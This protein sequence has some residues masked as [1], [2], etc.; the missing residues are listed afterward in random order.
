MP[1]VGESVADRTVRDKLPLPRVGMGGGG[2]SDDRDIPVRPATGGECHSDI[3]TARGD[4][5]DAAY[6][7]V[8]GQEVAEVGSAVSKYSM[9]D[10]VGVGCMVDS[11]R[12]CVNCK[13]GEEQYCFQ[14]NVGTYGGFLDGKPTDTWPRPSCAP[15]SRCTRRSGAGVRARARR[16]PSSGWAGSGTWA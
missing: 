1:P 3:H 9:G 4:W 13:A 16:S 10:R 15:A 7:L 11:C 6:P 2:R 8:P 5:G 12:E 14:G